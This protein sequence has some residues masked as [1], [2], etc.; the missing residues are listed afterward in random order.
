VF[1]EKKETHNG[2]ASTCG[3]N[4]TNTEK[5]FASSAASAS[6]HDA[7][8]ADHD[9]QAAAT[10][11]SYRSSTTDNGEAANTYKTIASNN[12]SPTD[13][14]TYCPKGFWV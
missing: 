4:T 9:R 7:K 14:C 12:R 3:Y 1:T 8:T 5:A 6:I 13:Y 11:Y 10:H 2:G